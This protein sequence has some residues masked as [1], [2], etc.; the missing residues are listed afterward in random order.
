MHKFVR[1][2]RLVLL[3]SFPVTSLGQGQYG[4]SHI[5][6]AANR[7]HRSLVNTFPFTL[8]EELEPNTFARQL[9]DSSG[10]IDFNSVAAASASG[11]RCI[12]KIVMEEETEYDDVY[13]CNHSYNRR[14]HTSFSTTYTAQQEEECEDNYK[15]S[16]FIQ[17]SPIAFNTTVKICRG[18][19]VKDCSA[20]GP[21]VC[22]TEYISECETTQDEHQVEDDVAD[23]RTEIQQKC[24]EVINGY[25][26][27]QECSNWPIEKC[28]LSK[29]SVTKYTP[30]TACN[31]VPVEICGPSSCPLVAGGEECFE[32]QKTITSEKPEEE[33]T[34]EPRVECKHV[35][36]LVPQLKPTEQCVD[37]PKEVCTRSQSNPR[38][39]KKPVI[40]KW[41]Y[42]PSPESGL[43]PLDNYNGADS[44]SE[45]VVAEVC[46]RHCESSISRGICDPRCEEYADLCGPCTPTTT[47]PACPLTCRPG[48]QRNS[49]CQPECDIPGCG[50]DPDCEP[51]PYVPPPPITTTTPPACPLTCRPGFQRNSVCQLECDIPECGYDPD[52]EPT[53][54][55]PPP[56]PAPAGGRG[57]RGGA[58]PPPGARVATQ[59]DQTHAERRELLPCRPGEPP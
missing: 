12:D 14:C 7:A 59:R 56:T 23:C 27:S 22:S 58:R 6:Q 29:K 16:C 1:W 46:P 20:S 38:K 2:S 41:C 50:Y 32:K 25:T 3:L 42:T 9:D 17:Y 18:T 35:T 21:T 45:P 8:T 11:Q 24:N 40:K 48:F 55:N 15:K 54:F 51:S 49:V 52:C 43:E 39:V 33:C 37:V 44:N 30:K 47:P 34:L 19:L 31:K 13:E 53:P 4:H 10:S 36:K 28:D 26:T 5:Q 57:R